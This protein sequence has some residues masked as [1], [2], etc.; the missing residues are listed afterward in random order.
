M[1]QKDGRRNRYQ[2]EAHLPLA[3]PGTGEPAI[4]EVL[5]LLLGQIGSRDRPPGLV[6]A[7]PPDGL[8]GGAAGIAARLDG[9]ASSASPTA[10]A[11]GTRLRPKAIFARRRA[12]GQEPR[13]MGGEE[14]PLSS[15]NIVVLF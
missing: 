13:D 7:G 1:K 5:A 3:E 2:I 4:G 8:P 12:P 6:G 9:Q 15:E 11:S 14:G 10:M